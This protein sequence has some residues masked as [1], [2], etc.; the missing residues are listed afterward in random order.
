MASPELTVEAEKVE[1]VPGQDVDG[2]NNECHRVEHR[3]PGV[4]GPR[5]QPGSEREAADPPVCPADYD[6]AG[7]GDRGRRETAAAT[8]VVAPLVHERPSVP[9]VALH[10][11]RGA[12]P[13]PRTPR[14]PRHRRERPRPWRA[15]TTGGARGSRRSRTRTGRRCRRGRWGL[16]RRGRQCHRRPVEA[17]GDRPSAA[18]EGRVR[19]DVADLVNDEELVPLDARRLLLLG[20]QREKGARSRRP[21]GRRSGR[22]MAGK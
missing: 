3:R 7:A 14:P 15:S 18:P 4:V 9:P 13:P 11:A 20:E 2:S 5:F 6:L 16:A 1:P 10:G 8:E 21:Q 22:V 19:D 12:P 17:T